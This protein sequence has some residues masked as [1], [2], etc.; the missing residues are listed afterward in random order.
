MILKL[1]P[2]QEE[3]LLAIHAAF[4]KEMTRQLVHLPTASGKTVI[5][6]HLIREKNCRTLVLAHTNEL[7]DQAKE[8]IQMICPDLEVGLVNAFKKEFD[9]PVIVSTIQ[10]ARQPENLK[11]LQS[12]NFE[13]LIYDEAHRSATESAQ[14]VLESLGFGKGTK[15]LL[16]GFSATPLR[17]DG[18]GLGEVFDTV[19]YHKS[20]QWM[21]DQGYLCPP[22]GIQIAT[23]LDLSQVTIEN[24]D[25]VLSSLVQVMDTDVLNNLIVSSFLEKAPQR[26]AICFTVTIE[27][28]HHLTEKFRSHG[29]PSETISGHT[30]KEKRDQI[31]TAFKEGKIS[32][33]THIPRV[34][35]GHE[36]FLARANK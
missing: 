17:N 35:C 9:K 31:I 24:G 5:F 33:L 6:A 4:R 22:K 23:D 18:K 29:L 28:A 30:T 36:D 26:K 21:I 3:C 19:V 27:H 15:H 2:Y 8:K 20:I 10:S 12:Q 1:R 25:F 13:L 16:M 7:I 34:A 32:V 11:Q 14:F